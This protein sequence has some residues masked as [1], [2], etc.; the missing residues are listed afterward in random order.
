M[1]RRMR[2][3][4]ASNTAPGQKPRIA[5]DLEVHAV[6]NI[7]LKLDLLTDVIEHKQARESVEAQ[8]G[9]LPT[10]VRQ[11]NL[12]T[13][14]PPSLHPIRKNSNDTITREANHDLLKSVKDAIAALAFVKATIK[15]PAR[16]E[17]IATL[18]RSL[19]EEA[20]MRR[21]CERKI[22]RLEEELQSAN[23]RVNELAAQLASVTAE[24][25][26][27]LAEAEAQLNAVR[28]GGLKVA[29]RRE[30]RRVQPI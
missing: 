5:T 27:A 23:S 1:K 6:A 9:A 2:R 11:F 7:K 17:R 24:A 8:Y 4:E 21:I 18:R 14:A 16:E 29:S 20:C 30:G 19:Q 22:G 26:A 12:W 13:A 25:Q 10:S 3:G 15:R 28:R